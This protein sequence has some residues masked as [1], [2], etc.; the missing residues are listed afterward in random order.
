M[1]AL[2]VMRDGS[3]DLVATE[4]NVKATSNAVKHM[5][6]FLL[7]VGLVVWYMMVGIAYEA[8]G[9]SL[10]DLWDDIWVNANGSVRFM[11]IDTGVLYLAVLLFLAYRCGE[12]KAAKALLLTTVLGPS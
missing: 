10:G 4:E 3:S 12:S 2:A 6:K 9:I 7:V 1:T 5:Y 8:Y 11:M